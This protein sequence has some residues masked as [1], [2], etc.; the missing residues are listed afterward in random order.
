MRPVEVLKL[1]GSLFDLPGLRGRVLAECRAGRASVIV[2]GGGP[3]VDAVRRL[4]PR[5]R[6][7]VADAEA[8]E[9]RIALGA[10]RVSAAWA[11]AVLGVPVVSDRG[12][13]P[14]VCVWPAADAPAGG[15]PEAWSVTSDVLAARLAA[16]LGA[17]RLTLLKS[18]RPFGSLAAAV[19]AGALDTHFIAAA[20]GLDV[21]WVNLRAG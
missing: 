6:E 17:D 4:S 11:A 18:V 1:G 5:M 19:R 2:P 21:R 20:A 15:L 10:T 12:A 7:A 8:V 9:H 13:L 16:S 3:F 14:D